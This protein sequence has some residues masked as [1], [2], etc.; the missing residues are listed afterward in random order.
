M[1]LRWITLWERISGSFWFLPAL[2]VLAA[3]VLAPVMLAVDRTEPIDPSGVLAWLD[4]GSPDGARS[5]LS[6]VAGSMISVAGVTFS[7]TIATLSLASSQLGPRLLSTFMRDRGN[8]IVLGTFVA[9]FTYCLIVL[10]AIRGEPAVDDLEATAFVPH[11]SVSLAILL[12]I[13][14]LGV[15]I[16]FF[17]HVS[18][19]I[20]AQQVV[21][22]IGQELEAGIARLFASPSKRALYERELRSDDDIPANFDERA[23]LIDARDSGYLQAVDYELLQEVATKADALLVMLYRPGEF[24]AKGSEIAAIYPPEKHNNDLERGLF[25]ALTLGSERLRLQDVEFAIDQLVEVAVRALSPGINDPFTAI[26]CLD[27]LGTALADLAER[28]IPAGYYYD[29]DGHLRVVSNTV[30]F[31]G[32]VER[33]FDQIRRYAASDV[34]VT[35]RLLEVIAVVLARARSDDQRE[36]LV[37]QADIIRRASQRVIEE[38]A[39]RT[40]IEDR[41]AVIQTIQR[42]ADPEREA[43]AQQVKDTENAG[44][45]DE[46]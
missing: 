32:L 45:Q 44:D 24:V 3:L 6:T 18:T 42:S 37:R 28:D 15:L 39:D 10:R 25:D 29:D 46:A 36:A 34:A 16:Y 23:A 31:S 20:Q 1:R 38:E 8:Q 26:A 17:H 35:V 22:S 9:I 40:D 19:I 13:L 7:I 41:Y 14:S 2:M 43:A 33:A 11:L 5:L 30:T 27:R 12:A 21:A 4:A